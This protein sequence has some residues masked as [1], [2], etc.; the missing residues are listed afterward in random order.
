[1]PGSLAYQ[2]VVFAGGGSRCF[3]QAG[4]WRA[5]EPVLSAPPKVVA[6]ASA[7][8]STACHVFAGQ[9][10][11]CMAFY[12]AANQDR[13]KNFMPENLLGAGEVY[14]GHRVYRGALETVLEGEG[15]ARLREGPEIRVLMARPPAWAPGGLG[16]A[17]GYLSYTLEKRLSNPV[18]PKWGLSL[19]FRPLVGRA[20][21]C[22][23]S[24]EVADLVLASSCLPPLITVPGWQGKPVLDGGFI[25]NA[26]LALLAPEEG[27]VLVILTRRYPP[28]KLKGRPGLTYVQPSHPLV[29][30][31]FEYVDADLIQDAYEQGLADGELFLEQGPEALQR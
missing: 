31:K 29:I 16:T 28:E 13:A 7:G 24:K 19:G 20:D 5:L 2:S 17:L 18:H 8:A 4:F 15:M 9:A 30:S 22:R 12:R 1:M 3:W 21:L 25:D 27:P 14:A 26:P 23:S 11:A 10:E 6:A